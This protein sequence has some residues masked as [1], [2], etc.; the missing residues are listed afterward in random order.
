LNANVPGR[1]RQIK[2]YLPL[3]LILLVVIIVSFIIIYTKVSS[4][5]LVVYYFGETNTFGS[6]S[7]NLLSPQIANSGNNTFIVWSGTGSGNGNINLEKISSNGRP[8]RAINISNNSRN[9]TSAEVVT[10]GDNLYVVWSDN[11]GTKGVNQD[12]FFSS[13]RDNATSFDQPINLSKNSGNST[14]PEV[15]ASGDNV[16]VVWSDND[17]T[18]GGNQDIFFS[19][20]R[21]KGRSFGDPINLSKNNPNSTNP[22]IAASGD[23]VYVVWAESTSKETVDNVNLILKTSRDNGAHFSDKKTIKKDIDKKTHL[24]QI[25]AYGDN[26]YVVLADKDPKEGQPDNYR[27]ILKTST[28]NGTDFTNRKSINKDIDKKTHLPQIAAYGNN[29][30][31]VWSDNDGTKG[32]NQDIFF[33]SSRDK[34]RTFDE[35]INLS[36]D[37]ANSTKPQVSAS[38]NDIYVLWSDS[39]SENKEIKYKHINSV[40]L[41][42]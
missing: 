24:P 2:T 18:K 34:G 39:S 35:P 12:I 28:D 33:S 11:N 3:V 17:G 41:G 42:S 10:S 15:A 21:D 19:S 7:T 1:L 8:T 4:P 31:V 16:Y 40:M 25:A 36:N 37:K 22:E 14:Y 26:V 38:D 13:S 32:G 9:S 29:V 30:Y 20:S 6:S 23:N 5:S 27:V